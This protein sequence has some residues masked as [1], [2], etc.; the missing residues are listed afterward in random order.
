MVSLYIYLTL[1]LIGGFTRTGHP[2]LILPDIY[3][4]YEVL[5]TELNLLLKY[6]CHIIPRA[7]QV[8]IAALQLITQCNIW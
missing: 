6:Y 4:W 8:N 7:E 3:K 2:L 5:E 1:Y